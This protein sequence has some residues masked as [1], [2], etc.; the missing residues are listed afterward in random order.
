MFFSADEGVGYPM[1]PGYNQAPQESQEEGEQSHDEGSDDLEAGEA[2]ED[3][4]D[5]N[6]GLNGG[7][8][9]RHSNVLF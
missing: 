5:E 6:A 9:V 8:R 3:T 1:P 4:D 7:G 2:G